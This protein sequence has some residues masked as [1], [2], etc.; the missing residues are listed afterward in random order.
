M[1]FNYAGN[2][3]V[4]NCVFAKNMFKDLVEEGTMDHAQL[5]QQMLPKGISPAVAAKLQAEMNNQAD[6]KAAVERHQQAGAWSTPIRQIGL[7]FLS[8]K[9]RVPEILEMSAV[10]VGP[11]SKQPLPQ[12][13]AWEAASENRC[14]VRQIP[15]THQVEIEGGGSSCSVA[16]AIRA[17]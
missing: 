5:I 11:T 2:V 9:D 3:V 6:L 10:P 14:P 15:W 1:G 13:L 16:P 4:E 7:R 17:W 12:K 8:K